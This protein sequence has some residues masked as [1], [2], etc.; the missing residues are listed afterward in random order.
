[1]ERDDRFVHA[2]REVISGLGCDDACAA[3]L[4]VP[5]QLAADSAAASR[6]ID[7]KDSEI[8]PARDR[9]SLEVAVDPRARLA[10][11]TVAEAFLL[12]EA[13]QVVRCIVRSREQLL[14]SRQV[15]ARKISN[16][17]SIMASL[18]Q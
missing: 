14:Q 13:H 12:G 7:P 2:G 8:L 4:R 3:I 9:D 11:K 1:E 6:P 16:H 17:S 5:N 18:S 10:F 15:A